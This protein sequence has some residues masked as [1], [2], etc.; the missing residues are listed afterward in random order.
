MLYDDEMARPLGPTHNLENNTHQC[1]NCQQWLAYDQFYTRKAST[2]RN[3][4]KQKDFEARKQRVLKALADGRPV[5]NPHGIGYEIELPSKKKCG[6]CLEI[7][8]LNAFR[9]SKE[10]GLPHHICLSCVLDRQ[11]TYDPPV[12]ES[13][14]SDVL[15]ACGCGEYTMYDYKKKNG[16]KFRPGHVAKTKQ[17]RLPGSIEVIHKTCT[18]CKTCKPV[19]D[20]VRNNKTIDGYYIYCKKCKA[21]YDKSKRDVQSYVEARRRSDTHRRARVVGA[22]GSYNQTQLNARFEYFGNKCYLCGSTN[23]LTVDHVISLD[24]GGSNW[25]ANLRPCCMRCNAGKQNRDW[26]IYAVKGLNVKENTTHTLNVSN[27]DLT[28]IIHSLKLCKHNNLA[29]RLSKQHLSNDTE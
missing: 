28:L 3:C 23:R 13:K 18:K 17:K 27:D 1:K 25:P 21:A 24:Q 26:K 9:F 22:K 20:F 2:C 16:N 4:L 5:V 11:R 10:S 14:V 7:K 19:G 12:Y 29:N 6:K 8:P 15:C